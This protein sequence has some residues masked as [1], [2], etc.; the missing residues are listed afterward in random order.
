[1]LVV[2]VG[3]SKKT[4]SKALSVVTEITNSP[5]SLAIQ[6]VIK[7]TWYFD[8]TLGWLDSTNGSII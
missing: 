1:M 4:F 7:F 5:L 8:D 2:V 6:Y 3:V